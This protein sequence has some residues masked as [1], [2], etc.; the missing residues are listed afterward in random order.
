M[1]QITV[2]TSQDPNELTRVASLLGDAGVNIEDISANNIEETGLIVL[3]VDQYDKAL[4]ALRDARLRAITQDALVIR[5]EDKPGG[6]ATIARRLRD[7]G[8]DL[9]SMHILRREAGSSSLAS[10]VAT[11]N[12]K[13][14][15]VLADVVVSAP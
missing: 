3:S 10:L 13:A 6:L 11:D 4:Q 7:A 8:I 12:A 15:I 1:K 5:I 9:R 14:A 2:L